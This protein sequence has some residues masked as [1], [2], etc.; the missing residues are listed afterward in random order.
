MKV[1]AVMH[2]YYSDRDVERIFLDEKLA[3]AYMIKQKNNNDW[4]RDSY[5]IE[6]YNT[7]DDD[8]HFTEKDINKANEEIK[9]GYEFWFNEDGKTLGNYR[10]Y[11]DDDNLFGAFA[12]RT[13]CFSIFVIAKDSSEQEYKR[14]LK[15]ACDRR[16][17][18][19]AEKRGLS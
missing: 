13:N 11:N 12:R 5:T 1:Y 6:V 3:K 10:I 16:A 2:G 14:C 17:E 18:L 9:F 19:L 15:V 4:D 8:V 7:S